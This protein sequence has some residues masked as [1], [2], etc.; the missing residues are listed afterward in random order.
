MRFGAETYD[1]HDFGNR[2]AHLTNNSIGKYSENFSKSE[3]KG[4]MWSMEE[5]SSYIKVVL[6]IKR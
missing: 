6:P 1:I 3:I 4:N 2:F 5:F